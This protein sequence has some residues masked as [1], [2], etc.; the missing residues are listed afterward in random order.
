M[1]AQRKYP[2][3]L[4]ERA[5]KGFLEIR[6]AVRSLPVTAESMNQQVDQR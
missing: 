5:V 4:R 2:E 6:A 3:E 1:P